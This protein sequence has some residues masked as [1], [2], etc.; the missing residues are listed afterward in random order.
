MIATSVETKAP[1]LVGLLGKHG[2]PSW[3]VDGAIARAV[4]ATQGEDT[5][6]GVL[7]P[8]WGCVG[9]VQGRRESR[10]VRVRRISNEMW[11]GFDSYNAINDAIRNGACISS[12]WVK[13]GSTYS[14]ANVWGDW[15]GT[16]TN[17]PAGSVNGLLNTARRFDN[18]SVGAIELRLK[19]PSSGTRHLVGRTL[20]CPTTGTG[21]PELMWLYDRVLAYDNCSIS[22]LTTTLNNTLTALR[23]VGAGDTGLKPCFTVTTGLGGIA[24]NLTS[25]V[26]TDNAGNAAQTAV[27]G[28]TMPWYTGG[29]AGSATALAPVA[30]PH[31]TVNTI[32]ISPFIPLLA[33]DSGVRLVETFISSA[34]N[35]GNVTLALVK[36]LAFMWSVSGGSVNHLDHPRMTF[37]LPRIFD[38]AC[39][40]VLGLSSR[41][42]TVTYNATIRIAHG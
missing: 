17:P 31:D 2:P 6:S 14:R 15:W 36:P 19:A 4:H 42:N 34:V 24:S 41:S 29:P 5:V 28:Y 18:T 27:P 9:L 3:L 1:A 23:Y 32:T 22:T 33:G 40:S 20:C 16:G 38:T 30:V 13:D 8:H 12:P 39:L 21:V 11:L 10:E 26:Y 37:Q 35:T 25:F 7:V